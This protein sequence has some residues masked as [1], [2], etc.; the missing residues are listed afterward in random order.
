MRAAALLDQN[1]KVTLNTFIYCEKIRV[2]TAAPVTKM[3]RH[4]IL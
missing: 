3:G 4:F 1:K 2:K